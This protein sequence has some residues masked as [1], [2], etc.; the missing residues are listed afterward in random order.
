MSQNQVCIV[1]RFGKRWN[2]LV[3]ES[4]LMMFI[5]MMF[6]VQAQCFLCSTSSS[7]EHFSAMDFFPKL[8]SVMDYE[9]F[10][11]LWIF[12][13]IMNILH[14]MNI[15]KLRTF[16][17][18]K[19]CM[20]FETFPICDH[21]TSQTMNIFYSIMNIFQFLNIFHYFSSMNIFL[22]KL[23]TI[24]KLWTIFV[25]NILYKW[26]MNIFKVLLKTENVIFQK[27]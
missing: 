19:S 4:W 8:K 23:W 24:Y 2:V 26:I 6:S 16:F 10:S 1:T 25:L 21:F 15:F 9:H 22:V 11:K 17:Q 14:F 13:K 7:Y 20:D 12:K 18:M 3:H 5:L 27:N